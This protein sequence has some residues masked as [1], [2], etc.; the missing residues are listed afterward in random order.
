VRSWIVRRGCEDGIVWSRI[1]F[2]G[3]LDML[4]GDGVLGLIG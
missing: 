1:R 3:G 4:V 2:V